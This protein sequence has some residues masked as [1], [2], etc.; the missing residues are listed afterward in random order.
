MS[1][2]CPHS[3]LFLLLLVVSSL[4]A[5]AHGRLSLDYYSKTCPDFPSILLSTITS[6]QL[7]TPTTAPGLL[8]LFLH[9]CL[10]GSYDS[11]FLLS[12]ERSSYGKYKYPFAAK[13]SREREY[14]Q[15]FQ[16]PR[17]IRKLNIVLRRERKIYVLED[18]PLKEPAPDASEDD[19]SY[20]S[21]YMKDALDIQCIVLSSM[22]PELQRQ[23]E[24]MCAREIDQHLHELFQENA[25][26][27]KYETSCAPFRTM[28]VEGNPVGSHVL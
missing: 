11:S 1:F 26:V 18:E 7:S 28:L 16:L 23:H 15:Q 17:L 22:S 4:A 5:T 20:Y 8:R 12:P 19:Q 6:K 27:E 9:N 3:L 13:H 21:Q 25:R 14:P 24:N 2:G 10:P